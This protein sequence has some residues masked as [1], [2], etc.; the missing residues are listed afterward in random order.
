M[1]KCSK[2]GNEGTAYYARIQGKEGKA[3]FYKYVKHSE[4]ARAKGEIIQKT[5]KVGPVSETEYN[6][7][8]KR[9]LES[10]DKIELS[11]EEIEVLKKLHER[12]ISGRNVSQAKIIEKIL[13]SIKS[14]GS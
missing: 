11:T 1:E 5:C 2:C 6:S 12:L 3:Y 13:E 7:R 8:S 4:A 9:G 10:K 14:A